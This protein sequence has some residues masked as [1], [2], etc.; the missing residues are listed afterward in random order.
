MNIYGWLYFCFCKSLVHTSQ[1]TQKRWNISYAFPLYSACSTGP[2]SDWSSCATILQII[3]SLGFC[4]KS[5]LLFNVDFFFFKNKR[6]LLFNFHK[7]QLSFSSKK[8]QNPRGIIQLLL[9]NF[10]DF[11][12]LSSD[13]WQHVLIWNLADMFSVTSFCFAYFLNNCF[14]QLSL[15]S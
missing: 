14:W 1:M 2:W 5:N 12:Y 13:N 10:C 8:P 15:L 9:Q 11:Q 7:G 4:W 6:F 3:L